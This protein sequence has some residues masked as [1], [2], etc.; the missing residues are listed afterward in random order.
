VSGLAQVPQL[1]WHFND[2]KALF[3]LQSP[4]LAHDAQSASPSWQPGIRHIGKLE[5]KTKQVPS[6]ETLEASEEGDSRQAYAVRA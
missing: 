2:M 5:N 1:L 3:V 4:L 6:R